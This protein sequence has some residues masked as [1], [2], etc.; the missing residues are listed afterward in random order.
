MNHPMFGVAVQVNEGSKVPSVELLQHFGPCVVRDAAGWHHFERRPR[1]YSIPERLGTLYE[2]VVRAGGKNHVTLYGGN[3]LYDMPSTASFP[4][5]EAQIRGY[6]DFCVYVVTHVPGLDGLSF[7]NELNGKFGGGVPSGKPRKSA[8]ARLL[9][10]AVPAIRS[11]APSVK[12]AA[13]AF[14][15]HPSLDR[16]FIDIRDD[17]TLDANFDFDDVDEL[18]IH[19]ATREVEKWAVNRSKLRRAG[20][21]NP[22]RMT[23]FGGQTYV[24]YGPADTGFFSWYKEHFWDNDEV[25]PAGANFFCLHSEKHAFER[26]RLIT[27]PTSLEQTVTPCGSDFLKAKQEFADHAEQQ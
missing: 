14:I 2:N 3:K 24:N 20:I 19:P 22:I 9:S 26:M 17:K 21:A 12:I 11:A 1:E 13:G 4:I 25:P 6:V 27:D 10:A 15:G 5:T 8:Y 16:W 7:W 23:E 18:D